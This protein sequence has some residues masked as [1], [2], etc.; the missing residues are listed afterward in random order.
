[1]FLDFLV[2]MQKDGF[3]KVP[4]PPFMLTSSFQLFFNGR[5]AKNKFLGFFYANVLISPLLLKGMF[6]EYKICI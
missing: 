4:I 3:S 6:N 2:F 1:M 5:S